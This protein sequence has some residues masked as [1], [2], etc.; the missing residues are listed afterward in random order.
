MPVERIEDLPGP[1]RFDGFQN[2]EVLLVRLLRRSSPR[3]GI[4]VD[5][6]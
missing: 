3:Y 1:P 2:H 5:F 6:C 4:F